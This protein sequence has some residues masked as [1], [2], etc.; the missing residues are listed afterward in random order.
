[1]SRK[2]NQKRNNNIKTRTTFNGKKKAGFFARKNKS[3]A[4][5]GKEMIGVVQAN[6][7]GFGFFIPEDGSPDA[8][9]PPREM[10]GILNGDTIKARVSKDSRRQDRF[11]ATFVEIVKRAHPSMVG[12]IFKDGGQIFLKADDFRVTQPI[13]LTKSSLKA[14]VGQKGVA[15][16]TKWPG[17]GGAM[18]GQLTEILGMAGD[19][20]IDI[21]TIIRKYN[22][23]EQ[24]SSDV[25][26]QVKRL[27]ENPTEKD[28]AGRLDLRNTFTMTIDGADAKDFDDAISLEKQGDGGYRLGVHIA[29]VSHYVQDGTALDKEAFE[30]ATSVYLADRVMPMLPH[31]L[32][33]GL[34]SLREG[35]PRLT[36]S[37][38]LT[39]NSRGELV[40]TEFALSVIQS[41]RRGI[42]E[43]VQ[44]VLDNTASP[45]V[46][47][48]YS[49]FL[50]TLKEMVKLSGFIRR[51]REINGSLDFDFPEVRVV[52][53]KTGRAVDVRKKERL[54][55]HKLIEDFMVA[56]N[57]AV[58]AHLDKMQMPTLYRIHEPPNDSDLEELTN[59]L[60]AYRIPFKNF[61]LTTPLG[62][63]SL[64]RSVKGNS[65]EPVIAILSLRSLKLAV[66]STRNAGH[67]GLGL[68]SYCHFTS[69]IRCYPDLMVHRALKRLIAGEGKPSSA[70]T[71]PKM[72]LQCS[73]QERTA[74]KAERE[75]QK[76]LQL[77][78]MESKVNQAFEGPV[79][80][81]TPYGAYVELN[82]YGIE[83]FLPIE[84]F[85]DDDYKLDSNS[86][87][88]VGKRSG[89]IQMGDNLKVRVL[90]VD[91]VFQRLLLTR[92]YD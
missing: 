18:E 60:K 10:N 71:Y 54:G 81:L 51:Q 13:F 1:M 88:Y 33:D 31:S 44:Q 65:L 40:K 34:C 28:W 43:E 48:K 21:K 39:Y 17:N 66:Y 14:E 73:L 42:Y 16:I 20:G 87:S 29:D 27:P 70:H 74:E 47:S 78:F 37:A 83:G 84:N 64:L 79:K 5:A 11:A 9:L 26:H 55:T 85:K 15:K 46:L 63:Q 56:A 82:P 91:M 59:F 53:D 75:C 72:A 86:M 92:N 3:S 24:F 49:A 32:S 23:P 58:A 41:A 80:H 30:R 57:E 6:E 35:V 12:V 50:P 4:N 77:R 22:W 76:V 67:F 8:F 7:K 2:H 68:K 69:P 38:F 61:D 52:L 90:S 25:D 36:T 19:P 62:L 89:K 45:E